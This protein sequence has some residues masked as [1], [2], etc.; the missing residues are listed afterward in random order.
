MLS[1]GGVSQLL[2]HGDINTKF[3][4]NFKHGKNVEY[5][6]FFSSL[7]S[8]NN[9]R[10]LTQTKCRAESGRRGFVLC[11][12][13][14]VALVRPS[15]YSNLP[16]SYRGGATVLKVGGQILRANPPLFG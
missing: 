11:K 12:G 5:V 6:Y 7:C 10:V 9:L 8:R 1:Y 2:H 15:V 13:Q 3:C 16:V 4:Y 14:Q